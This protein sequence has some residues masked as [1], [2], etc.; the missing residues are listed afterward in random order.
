[1]AADA[2]GTRSTRL[3]AIAYGRLPLQVPMIRAALQAA[4][5]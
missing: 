3:K 1:M 2:S 5:A 4:R